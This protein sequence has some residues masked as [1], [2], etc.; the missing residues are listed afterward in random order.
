MSIMV[1]KIFFIILLIFK[2]N[3]VYSNIVYDKNS[4]SITEIEVN[5]YIQIYKD[6]SDIQLSTNKAIRDIVLM[7][8]TVNF[9]S[10]Y[11]SEFMA[12]LDKNI[13]IEFGKEAFKDEIFVNFIRFFKI[14]NEFISEYF[15][16]DFNIEELKN[17][18]SKFKDLKLPISKNNCLTI[19]RFY[20]FNNNDKFQII[21]FENLKK[22]KKSFKISIDNQPYDICIDNK[23]YKNLESNIIKYIENKTEDEFN[24]FI[25]GK[26]S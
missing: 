17:V 10:T 25:Y 12:V 24:K 19:D 4:I 15:Q 23:T 9:L 6:N 2:I 14:R 20:D 7:K 13:E 16:N 1:Y 11:N 3:I 5:R 21:F 8:K 18:F 26:K 22:N